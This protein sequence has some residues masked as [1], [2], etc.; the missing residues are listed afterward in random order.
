[1]SVIPFRTHRQLGLSVGTGS[2]PDLDVAVPVYN[3]E[4]QLASSITA[5]RAF[6]DSEMPLETVVTIVD[7]A[8]TDATPRIASD[9]AA[10]LPG[11]RAI[12][13]EQRGR[14]R[15]LRAAWSASE[16]P[17]VAYMD[18]DLSTR[19][20]AL[21]PLVAPIA[22]GH[23]DLSIGSR[24]APGA[25]VVRSARR[26]VISR[27]YNLLVRT[28]L[29]VATSDAQ[30]GFKA[31]RRDWAAELLPFVKDDEWFFDTELL[32]VAQRL[33]LRVHEVPVEWL[34]DLDS[35][36]ELLPTALADLRGVARLRRGGPH[37]LPARFD[38]DAHPATS[39]D[40]WWMAGGG[41]RTLVGTVAAFLLA[42]PLIGAVPAAWLAGLVTGGVAFLA[43]C[44]RLGSSVRR[45]WPSVIATAGIV[46]GVAP[47]LTAAG[48]AALLAVGVPW[49]SAEA[50]AV[51]GAATVASAARFGA[52]R[53]WLD[54]VALETV[55]TPQAV[56]SVD[57]HPAAARTGSPR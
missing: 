51:A 41:P 38:Q 36:V 33:G 52:L 22:S 11:V 13:L 18:V 37:A 49:L 2:L 45:P 8:S 16:A 46:A 53:A 44:R 28:V 20:D 1:M 34:D 42:E 26:E 3:E 9:V 40:L 57:G 43:N 39:S 30:C 5:L 17:I 10:A 50:V 32:V 6:L 56:D 24:L 29:G 12:R 47:A 31:I 21:L 15:A 27:A 25:R 14:G 19:L 35:R 54:P 23:S 4:A 55:G 48:P 7:N